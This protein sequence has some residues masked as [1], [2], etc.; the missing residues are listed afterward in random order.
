MA[1]S[2]WRRA[3]SRNAA[4]R[5]SGGR[6]TDGGDRARQA[7]ARSPACPAGTRRPGARA[8]PASRRST[9]SPSSTGSASGISDA[10]SAWA[11]EPQTC[12]CCGSESGRP[13]AAPRRAAAAS[14]QGRASPAIGS[15]VTAAPTSILPSTSRI[16]R[17]R[18]CGDV[19]H[20]LRRDQP[21]IEHR[22]QRLAAGQHARVIAVLGED[23]DR[24]VDRCPAGHSRTDAASSAG[25]AAA[26]PGGAALLRRR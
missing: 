20:D 4:V 24:L 8:C 6:E 26:R 11:I 7:R 15:G 22:Q 23:L 25:S 14:A 21:Q 19:D 17:A 12:P 13:R 5:R 3:T 2:P 9:T 1:K 18:R 16:R 10:G